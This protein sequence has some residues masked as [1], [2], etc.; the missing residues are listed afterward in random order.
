MQQ[1][2]MF[3]DLQS[4]NLN[5]QQY[6]DSSDKVRR[7]VFARIGEHKKEVDQKFS[8]YDNELAYIKHLLEEMK[9]LQNYAQ[10]CVG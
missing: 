5:V 2:D 7:G 10:E 8:H 1:L 4:L 6:K 3:P 9:N